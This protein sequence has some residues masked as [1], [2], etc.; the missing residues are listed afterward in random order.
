VDVVYAL[1]HKYIIL[2]KFVS[3]S[4]VLMH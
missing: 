4:N 1:R 3:S 2:L